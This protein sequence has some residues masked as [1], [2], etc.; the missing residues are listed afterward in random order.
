MNLTVFDLGSNSFQLLQARR[1]SAGRVEPLFSA[2][3]FVQL[4]K[5]V[6]AEHEIDPTGFQQGI[7][8][9]QRL[10]A[11]APTSAMAGPVVAVAT[12]AVRDAQNGQ[13]FLDAVAAHTGLVARIVTGE[14]EAR[15]T[16]AGA[17]SEF[18]A[19]EEATAVVDLGGGST[20][21][22]WGIGARCQRE[23]SIRLGVLA[24]AERLA[25]LSNVG[26]TA[27]DQ[28]ATYVRRTI[29]PVVVRTQPFA[30]NTL[31]FAS[32]V[33]RVTLSLVYSYGLLTRGTT[34][35]SLVLAELVPRLLAAPDRELL[36]RG[37]PEK[38]L[39]SVGPTA[40]VLG[41]ITDLFELDRFVVSRSGLREGL[42]LC[43]EQVG[44][45]AWPRIRN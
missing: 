14:E 42:A 12:C 32:G 27:L 28:M 3:E 18:G 17:A 26:T 16:Y 43:A 19:S 44:T 11:Q 20:E 25:G 23:A 33:A 34:V 45:Q 15:F 30:P 4:A 40:V 22:A 6:N 24:L 41:V 13:A 10:L 21:I 5:Y 29:E 31:V 1:T 8:A 36:E 2:V 38:R 9:V 7:F 39:A 37:V 35:P